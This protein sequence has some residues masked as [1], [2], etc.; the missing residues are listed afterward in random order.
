MSAFFSKKPA[1]DEPLRNSAF[2]FIKP[3]ANTPEVRNLARTV[4]AS[5]SI[6]IVREGE[7]AGE[8]IDKDKLID[9]HY[10]AIASKATLTTPD[11]L[12][13]P[14]AK[15]RDRER[16]K[17]K[18][19]FFG[20]TSSS[21]VGQFEAKFGVSWRQVLAEKK[22]FNALDACTQ[23]GVDAL[24]LDKLWAEAKK[25]DQLLKAGGGFYIGKVGEIFV[26]NGFFM[27]MRAKF[28]AKGSSIYYYVVEWDAAALSW[29]DFRAKVLGPTDPADAPADSLRGKILHD[30][31]ALGLAAK[32]NVGDNGVHA[33]ASPFEALAER[34][35]WLRASIEDDAFGKRLLAAGIS[36]KTIL[37][38]SVD[39]QVQYGPT[40]KQ[41]SLFDSLE[42]T[43]ADECLA[44]AQLISLGPHYNAHAPV[45]PATVGFLALG[46]AIGFAVARALKD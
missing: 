42:D 4:L 1:S 36:K 17:K 40:G 41:A 26:L 2:V 7:L 8:L 12:A 22:A 3:H 28:V 15:V 23:L 25:A 19:F 11:K 10:Y 34:A 5:K 37:D 45:T 43:D 13:V 21:S 29:K 16:E 27:S 30:W 24:G 14:E 39:P 33:S 9:Q 35:N 32:P 18:L 46:V 20:S 6:S 31:Q 44:R 38:W